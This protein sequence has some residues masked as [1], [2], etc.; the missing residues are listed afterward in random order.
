MKRRLEIAQWSGLG[1][2]NGICLK[3]FAM[4][5]SFLFLDGAVSVSG[6]N[7]I[8][9]NGEVDEFY[10]DGSQNIFCVCLEISVLNTYWL[11][12]LVHNCFYLIFSAP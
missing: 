8:I 12:N 10:P 6:W 2:R 9:N 4:C 3:G 7:A 5:R 11:L 1:R